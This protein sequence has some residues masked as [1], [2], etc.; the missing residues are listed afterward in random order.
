MDRSR[1]ELRQTM[2]ARS[3]L[4]QKHAPE[5]LETYAGA[6]RSMKAPIVIV[7]DATE[8]LLGVAI[9]RVAGRECSGSFVCA[10]ERDDL[11]AQAAET[12][13]PRVLERLKDITP[14]HDLLFCIVVAEGATTSGFLARDDAHNFY[15][16][17]SKRPAA[18]S[19]DPN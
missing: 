12:L 17:I 7:A 16:L 18:L 2:G 15:F 6:S 14:G 10:L 1:E 8:P 9:A 11:I 4:L 19:S 3:A 13:A 5:V